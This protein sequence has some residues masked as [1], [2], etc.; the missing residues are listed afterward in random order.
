MSVNEYEAIL[1]QELAQNSEPSKDYAGMIDEDKNVQKRA[2]RGSMYLAAGE[3]PDRKAK[4]VSLANQMNVAPEFVERNYDSLQKSKKVEDF[5][6]GKLIDESPEL[7]KWLEDPNNASVAHDDID[8]LSKIERDVSDHSVAWKALA[9]LNKTATGMAASTARFPNLVGGAVYTAA[10]EAL[11]N[12][13][14]AQYPASNPVADYFDRQAASFGSQT[15]ELKDDVVGE[16]AKGNYKKAGIAAAYQVVSQLPQLA[17]TFATAGGSS[18]VQ[19]AS[20]ASLGAMSAADK[21][22]EL[23]AK[24]ISPLVA[25]PNA[26]ATGSVESLTEK[27]GTFSFIE[28]MSKSLVE[29]A[30]KQGA[31]EV[32]KSMGKVMLSGSATEGTEEAVGQFVTGLMDY[33]TGVDPDAIK[34]LPKNV[35]NA[36]LLGAL[37]GGVATGPGTTIHAANII[38]SERQTTLAKE[39]YLSF[40]TTAEATKLRKRLPEAQKKLVESIVKDSPVENIYISTEALERFFQTQDD[41]ASKLIQ[42]LGISESFNEAKDTGTDVKIPMAVVADKL[43]GTPAHAA[44]ANDIKFDPSHQSVNERKADEA[45]ASEQLKIEEANATKESAPLTEDQKS[46]Q[47]GKAVR[48]DV[49]AQLKAINQDPKQAILYRGFEVLGKRSGLDPLELYN[50]YK[51]KI[52]TGQQNI[53]EPDVFDLAIAAQKAEIPQGISEE[54]VKLLQENKSETKKQ[55]IAMARNALENIPDVSTDAVAEAFGLPVNEVR[56]L[57]NKKRA[58]GKKL[59]AYS[60]EEIR[61][62]A[63]IGSQQV[64]GE[65]LYQNGEQSTVGILAQVKPIVLEKSKQLKTGQRAVE[66]RYAEYLGTQDAR[67]EYDG[68][69]DTEG[70]KIISA[71]SARFLA[72]EYQTIEGRIVHTR[73]TDRA[74]AI[75]AQHLF[76]ERMPKNGNVAFTSGGPGSGK[77]TGLP[78]LNSADLIFDHVGSN[79]ETFQ[80]NIDLA[81]KN[82]N[83]VEIAFTYQELGRASDLMSGRFGEMGR[84]IPAKGMV[85]MHIKALNTILNLAEMYKD[86]PSVV[87]SF[88]DNSPGK[89]AE[90]SL[91]QLNQLRYNNG[92]ETVDEAIKRLSPKIEEKLK[93]VE[94]EIKQKTAAYEAKQG[95]NG[96]GQN[97][98]GQSQGSGSQGSGSQGSGSRQIDTSSPQ[99]KKWFGESKVVDKKG[100]PIVVYH[101]SNYSFDAFGYEKMGEKG[102]SEGR[103]F[104]FSQ[105][106]KTAKGYGKNLVKAYVNISNPASLTE[107]T[108]TKSDIKK[109]IKSHGNIA[110]AISNWGDVSYDGLSNVLNAAV[111]SIYNNDNDVDI[112]NEIGTSIFHSQWGEYFPLVKE[113]LGFDGTIFKH[114]E[115]TNYVVF[116]PEDVKSVDNAGSFDPKN[117]NIYFQNGEGKAPRGQITFGSNRQFNIDI[118]KDAN[119]STFI[120]ETGH[121]YVEVMKDITDD[122]R[123]IAES[124]RTEQQTQLI[125]DFET[126]LDYAGAKVGDPITEESHEKL[127]RAFEKYLYEGKAPTQELRSAFARFRIWLISVYKQFG[128]NAELSKDVRDV[129]DRLLATDEEINAVQLELNQQPLFSDPKFQGMSIE[130]T[131]AYLKAVEAA[132]EH[133]TAVINKKLFDH[134]DRVRSQ[135]YK[136]ERELLLPDIR[137][138]VSEIPIYNAID[139]MLASDS[140]IKISAESVNAYGKE[141]KNG[142]PRGI[143]SSKTGLDIKIVAEMLGYESASAFITDLTNAEDKESLINKIADQEMERRFPDL[144]KTNLHEEVIEVVH[145]R[146]R[147]TILR[148]ELEHLATYNMPVLKE[149]I[150]RVVRRPPTDAAVRAQAR[151]II[152]NK[153]VSEIKPYI[154]LRAE[155]K[156]V[157]QAG[158]LYAKG[159]FDGAFQAKQKELLNHELY[160]AATE[161]VELKKKSI[162]KLK[163]IVKS[164]DEDIAKTRDTDIVNAAKSILANF[165]IGYADKDASSYLEKMKEYDP[166]TYETIRSFVD[167]SIEGSDV[168]TNVTMDRF[169]EM[170]DAVYSLWDLAKSEKEIDIGGVK[171]NVDEA[172]V[173]VQEQIAKV[174]SS[175]NGDAEYRRTKTKWE[176]FKIALAEQAAQLIRV[177]SWVS[178][179]DIGDINGP[180]RKVLWNTIKDST[181]KY[182][183]IKKT[184]IGKQQALITE[185]GKTIIDRNPIRSKELGHEFN[186]KTQLMMALLHSGNDSNLSKLLRGW[187]WG[188]F[189]EDGSLDRSKWDA[190]ILRMQSEGVLT[191]ADYDFAQG[192]WDLLESIKPDAQKAHKQMYGY[193]FNEI[194]ANEI[195][196]PFGTYR[197]G[198]IPAKVDMFESEDAAIRNERELFEKNN[199]SFQF[200]TTGRGFSK[201]RVDAYAAPLSLDLGLLSGHIDGVL[202]FS[203]IEPAVKQVMK[204]VGN[205]EFRSVLAALDPSLGKEVLVPWLQRTA[206][207]RV[208]LQSEMGGLLNNTAAF[209]RKSAAMQMMVLNIKNTLEQFGGVFVAMSMVKPRYIRNALFTYILSHGKTVKNITERSAYMRE[210]QDKTI[211][212]SQQAIEEIIVNPSTFENMQNFAAKHT[213]FMQAATQNIVNSIAWTGAYNEG[214]A[215]Y[216]NEE[217]AVMYADSVIRQTQGSSAPEDVSR[218]ETGTPMARLFT[219]FAGYF[220]MIYNLQKTQVSNTANTVGLKKGA[221]K[222]FYLYMTTLMLP[223]V[224][225]LLS[226]DL[227]TGK[228]LED[229]DDDGYVDDLLAKLFGY[230]ASTMMATIPF[231]GQ[232]ANSTING[233]NNNIADDRIS[234]SPVISLLE[235]AGKVPSDVYKTITGEMDNDKKMVKDILTLIGIASS[236]PVAPLSKPIG[237]AIDV[238]EGKIDPSGPID[239]AIGAAVGRAPPKK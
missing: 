51:L 104:Y 29:R 68:L 218:F 192:M 35:L 50:K 61:A 140:Q 190:F 100:N 150:R 44:L 223:S 229:D 90:I 19:A 200:P 201:N 176:K 47:S 84:S 127:A 56:L 72:P 198:Y 181:T 42:D 178:S 165:G 205:K 162:E 24:G 58:K 136:A 22:K 15:P 187:G 7:S 235:S 196:T 96:N 153:K 70:G 83:K 13:N 31:L 169:I 78:G 113:K 55:L 81:L 203:N 231:V 238:S 27:L 236:L 46:A 43:A 109:L 45:L 49:A 125:K 2:V 23:Q 116:N 230:Q 71:D 227:L 6:Y 12:K 145:N 135:E 25:I 53:N 107:K 226:R 21:N 60:V 3:D 59:G 142:F 65:R 179:V 95:A 232:L 211:Y 164:K 143:V 16:I 118:L 82:G 158:I 89:I 139:K 8:S 102:T 93:N 5:D 146:E 74:S 221:G 112:I 215:K 180:A 87:F 129:M 202:R 184:V 134:H 106:E 122:L 67:T 117:K 37:T 197:G 121:F 177:E 124:D 73:T 77:S 4:V 33:G 10:Q 234:A 30:G 110:D 193:Y 14:Y 1:D 141:V 222:L 209:L 161:A 159:D 91:E 34:N 79:Q 210:I 228:L 66:S 98:S 101:G 69:S 207:Q 157:N 237:Y 156:S 11:G 28:K 138:K 213:Y 132:K 97:N 64:E 212:E 40:G 217:Q 86:N 224:V 115:T 166:Q 174:T 188:E 123:K 85:N 63:S 208:V 105:S 144:L 114:G 48:D 9:A 62:A 88:I 147:A 194:T 220:N 148:M 173:M 54:E 175:K 195:V 204:I 18:A 168:Y 133:A 239:Y 152:G 57:G 80:K 189:K 170:R 111:D 160:L 151:K 39:F 75:F 186:D 191:K 32:F 216:N 130:K 26:L 155:V 41:G 199:N 171:V 182:R 149:G 38:A 154:Y 120:H 36:G 233:F 128:P 119:K 172:R 206:T 137:E 99:F 76:E 225:S 219:Q 20:L 126:L 17:V 103:G 92:N 52:G 163:K 185:W 214:I 131:K 183:A 167:M 108:I 94:E